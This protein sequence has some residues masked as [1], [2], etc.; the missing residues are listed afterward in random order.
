MAGRTPHSLLRRILL[1]A[2]LSMALSGCGMVNWSVSN[3][4]DGCPDPRGTV[5]CPWRKSDGGWRR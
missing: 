5:P 4:S 2:G 1:A 3:S